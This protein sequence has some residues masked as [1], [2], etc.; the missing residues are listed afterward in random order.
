MLKLANTVYDCKVGIG[1]RIP[2]LLLEESKR[3]LAGTCEHDIDYWTGKYKEF[4]ACLDK[5][6]SGERHVG[7]GDPHL[8]LYEPLIKQRMSVDSHE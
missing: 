6:T 8:E 4:L 5:W 1:G 2:R 7:L 3:S